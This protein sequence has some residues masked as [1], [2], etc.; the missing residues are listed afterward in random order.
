[1]TTARPILKY[2]RLKACASGCARQLT[3]YAK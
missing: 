2:G 1:M 3:H